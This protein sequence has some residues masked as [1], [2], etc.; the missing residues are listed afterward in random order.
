MVLSKGVTFRKWGLALTSVVRDLVCGRPGSKAVQQAK[1]GDPKNRTDAVRSPEISVDMY[2]PDS[3]VGSPSGNKARATVGDAGL[4]N[5]TTLRPFSISN[6]RWP[7]SVSVI[8]YF[9]YR[10]AC[11]ILAQAK[12][13]RVL[14]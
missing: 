6:A 4:P 5:S 7:N 14:Y 8:A 2:Y 3:P 11:I 12:F 10:L 9:T 1:E 13:Q